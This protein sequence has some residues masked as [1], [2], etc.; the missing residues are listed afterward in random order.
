[1][2]RW[3]LTAPH[4]LNVEGTEWQYEEINRATGKPKRYR[5][6]VPLHL[7]PDL[8]SDWNHVER[9]VAGQITDGMVVVSDGHN[10]DSKDIIFTGPPTPDMQPLDDD[11]RAISEAV[12]KN[13][14]HPIERL[15]GEPVTAETMRESLQIHR[16]AM[17]SGE[18]KP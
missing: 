16:A 14:I 4:Y 12:G 13:W 18:A 11:A 5:L 10:P 6:P 8:E 1:M 7:H 2:A 17:N 9:N 15:V 3:K